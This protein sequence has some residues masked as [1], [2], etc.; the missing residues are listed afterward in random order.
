MTTPEQFEQWQKDW[1]LSR[2]RYQRR[3]WCVRNGEFRM[4]LH[5]ED[6]LTRFIATGLV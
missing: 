1:Y 3:G 5:S 6:N 2:R 4:V